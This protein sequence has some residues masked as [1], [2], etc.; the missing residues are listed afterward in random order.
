MV[1]PATP[2]DVSTA[3]AR[4]G[5]AARSGL[6]LVQIRQPHLDARTLFDLVCQ[7]VDAVRG[8]TTRVIVNDRLDV[9]LAA[10]AHGVH[11][12]EESMAGARVRAVT[13]RGFLVG[14]SVHGADAA[15]RAALDATDYL[16]CGTVFPTASKPGVASAG[17]DVLTSV[18]GSTSLPVLAIGGVTLER[19][20]AIAGSGASGIA[21]I[22][23]FA[24]D[25][26]ATSVADVKRRWPVS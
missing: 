23:L 6:D 22:G 26:G 3:V 16:I 2:D 4:I 24:G 5:D 15:R 14:R 19:L 8:S 7:A 18:V 20:E 11:L 1:T 10:G 12:R 25:Q 17:I 13:P 9:A 21:A